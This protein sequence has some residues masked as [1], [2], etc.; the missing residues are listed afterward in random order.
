MSGLSPHLSPPLSSLACYELCVQSPRHVV[1]FL[2][3]VH[4]NQPS[5]LREDFCGTGA[6]SRRWVDEGARRG[7][8][9]R[10]T[11]VDLSPECLAHA[12]EAAPIEHAQQLR[13]LPL[14]CIREPVQDDDGCDVIFIGN[15]SL[16]YIHTRDELIAYL[17]SCHKRLAKGNAG[18]GGGVL[19]CD[20]YGGPGAFA[21]GTLERT[22][23]GRGKEVI[24]YLWRHEQADPCTAMVT[25]SIS[26]R[27]L[28]DG[29]VVQ[30]LPRAFVYEWRLWSLPEL[31]DVL[32]ESGFGK[33][34]IYT[35]INVAPGQAAIPIQTHDALHV[36]WVACIAARPAG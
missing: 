33:A 8:A 11:G 27:V 12:R 13:W 6:V 20:L 32:R 1:S 29:D 24:K 34:V 15:F 26:L 4:G 18:F 28:I 21:L 5:V 35:D 2:R 23:A 19:V 16:G 22:H 7:E 36:D 30:D 10:A 31:A 9:W 14:D 17:L 3:A 25:N